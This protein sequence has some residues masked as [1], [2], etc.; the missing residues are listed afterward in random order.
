[1]KVRPR[2]VLRTAWGFDGVS[3]NQRA[4]LHF[5]DLTLDIDTRQLLRGGEV[6]AL[7]PKAFQ[8]VTILVERRPRAISKTELTEVLW[9]NT[10]VA[11]TN[12]ASLIAEIRQAIRDSAQNPRFIRTVH[13]FGYAF[14]GTATED[15]SSS[16]Q[17]NRVAG[18]GCWLICD[19]RQVP[20]GEGE[21][22]IGREPEAAVW[23]DFATVSRRH[24]RV[25]IA[26]RSATVEDLGSKNGTY[27][28][29]SRITAATRIVDGDE[30]RIGSVRVRFRMPPL[31]GSTLSLGSRDG[32]DPD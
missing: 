3:M 30:I 8:L 23:L 5:G 12:L 10:Y 15:G 20:L 21:N 16:G 6:V 25:M 1:M 22:V 24:A 29:D 27:V 9:P 32:D 13:R 14:S 17:R 19:T 4:R 11:E 2:P 7:S 31:A 26:G 28:R 18:L